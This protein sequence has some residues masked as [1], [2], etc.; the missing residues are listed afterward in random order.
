MV[1]SNKS[2]PLPAAA[3]VLMRPKHGREPSSPASP[4]SS[5]EIFLQRRHDKAS[6][7]SSAYVFPGGIADSEDGGDLRV[8][9]IRE[10]FEEAGVL[11]AQVPPSRGTSAESLASRLAAW[12]EQMSRGTLS[13]ADLV[14][15]EQ[16]VL[17]LPDLAYFAR[18][19]T[20]SRSSKR[21]DASFYLAVL[22][23]GQVPSE[24][25]QEM[26]DSRWL[27][28][29]E[30]LAR[31]SELQLPPPQIRSLY[32]LAPA[33][34]RGLD[35]VLALARDRSESP[36]ALLPRP[37]G[38]AETPTLLLPWDPEYQSAGTGEALPMAPGHQWAVGPSRFVLK[39][40]SWHLIN[41]P[42]SPT[43]ASS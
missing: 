28:P 4:A 22:P 18:W 41:A 17:N 15:D 32:E 11:L 34:E 38:N 19:I 12:R 5:V 29:T 35:A 8:T 9:A 16:I 39:D 37:H 30:A 10:L 43:A 20:P 26:V 21:F 7:M 36:H 24:D 40:N 3:V 13:L 6:F 42:D 1:D 33:A 31:S 23:P 25:R 14:A 27:T 2:R